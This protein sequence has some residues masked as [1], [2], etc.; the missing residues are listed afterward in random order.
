MNLDLVY[1]W[2]FECFEMHNFNEQTNYANKKS[3]YF[4]NEP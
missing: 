3:K 4:F 1:I 2:N